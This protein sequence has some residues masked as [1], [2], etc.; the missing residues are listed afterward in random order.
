V[1]FFVISVTSLSPLPV[2]AGDV[3]GLREVPAGTPVSAQSG[4]PWPATLKTDPQAAAAS[5][6]EVAGLEV[7]CPLDRGPR[8]AD[9]D[10]LGVRDLALALPEFSDGDA[11][12]LVGPAAWGV[13]WAFSAIAAA[14]TAVPKTT[15]AATTITRRLVLAVLAR[16]PILCIRTRR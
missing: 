4:Q 5:G 11:T 8:V 10:D 14:A 15:A 7:T 6:G 16:S 3:I 1:P 9:P 2:G 12:W 13:P